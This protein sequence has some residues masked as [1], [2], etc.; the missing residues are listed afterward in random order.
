MVEVDVSYLSNEMIRAIPIPIE[1]FACGHQLL[2]SLFNKEQKIL[3]L[4]MAA[5]H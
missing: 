5:H 2:L 1:D 3:A 4:M